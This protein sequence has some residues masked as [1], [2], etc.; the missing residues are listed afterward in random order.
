MFADIGVKRV[1]VG[2]GFFRAAYGAF[3]SAAEE[4]L[5][6][7]TFK[8]GNNAKSSSALNELFK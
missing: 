5:N 1:S 8:F 3:Y 4:V 2:A 7:G 6:E